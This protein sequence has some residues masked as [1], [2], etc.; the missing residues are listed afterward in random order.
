VLLAKPFVHKLNWA[1]EI[2]PDNRPVLAALEKVGNGTKV[3]P[4]QD[5]ATN[6]YSTAFLPS[7]GL[8]YLQTLEKCDI[9]SEHP[10][11]WQAG[12]AYLGGSQRAAPGEVPQKILRAIDIQTGN[13]SWELPQIGPAT[14]W[15]GVLA[16][17]TG[18][19]FFCDDSRCGAFRRIKPGMHRPLATNSMAN[20][21]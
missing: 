13:I 16:T 11:E 18:V 15:G 1:K 19:L 12:Q 9:Y 7:T 8:Y 17:A 3:C 14:T 4:S 2:G 10:A 20:N 21:M 5:G 6:W